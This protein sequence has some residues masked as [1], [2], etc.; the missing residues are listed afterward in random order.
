MPGSQTRP[1][2]WDC[3]VVR[4]SNP[5]LIRFFDLLLGHDLESG[6]RLKLGNSIARRPIQTAASFA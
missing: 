1:H 5:A 6:Y 3:S 4:E 2:S